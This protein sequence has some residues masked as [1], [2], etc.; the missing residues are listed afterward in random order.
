M[1]DGW[2]RDFA[3]RLALST[4]GAFHHSAGSGLWLRS[5]QARPV[6]P[7]HRRDGEAIRGAGNSRGDQALPDR[8]GA[9]AVPEQKP[10]RL[11]PVLQGIREA[12]RAWLGEYVAR[13]PGKAADH[14]QPRTRALE[15]QGSAAR[16]E[17]G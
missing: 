1:L 7:G 4:N 9:R 3:L 11:R 2:V 10:A 14:L 6:S 13:R 16:D 17:R 8:S 5:R 15:A 12:F